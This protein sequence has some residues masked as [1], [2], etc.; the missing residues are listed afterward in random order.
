M[1]FYTVLL[2][3]H[4]LYKLSGKVML[5]NTNVSI[6]TNNIINFNTPRREKGWQYL[7][8]DSL[9][10]Q[11][12]HVQQHGNTIRIQKPEEQQLPNWIKKLIRS[13]QCEA[14]F[15]ENLILSEEEHLAIKTL[16]TEFSVSLVGLT[17]NDSDNNNI[18]QGPW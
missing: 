5:A 18:V 16:C 10:F 12:E 3:T 7:I 13:G 6:Q 9:A 11:K 15:V 1:F 14:I 17:V 2:Y 4:T 8:A